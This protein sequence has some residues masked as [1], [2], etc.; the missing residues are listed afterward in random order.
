VYSKDKTTIVDRREMLRVKV[1]SLAAEAR[2]IRREELRTHGPL[3]AELYFHRTGPLRAEAGAT[4]LAY[5]FIRGRTLEQ[6]EP[7]RA[8]QTVA[9]NLLSEE[10]LW[11]KVSTMLK[12]YGPRDLLAPEVL[13]KVA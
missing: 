8:G 1:K 4:H 2:I 6:T 5:G 11:D 13:R 3:R 9:T 12:K 10:Q 7:S